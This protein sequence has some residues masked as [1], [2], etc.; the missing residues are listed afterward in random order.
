MIPSACITELLLL[1]KFDNSNPLWLELKRFVTWLWANYIITSWGGVHNENLSMM[2]TYCPKFLASLWLEIYR[3]SNWSFCYFE[4][5]KVDT[6]FVN[7][8]QVKIDPKWSFLLTL[9]RS[10]LFYWVWARHATKNNPKNSRTTHKIWH[11]SFSMIQSVGI[12]NWFPQSINRLQSLSFISSCN[13]FPDFCD[14][15]KYLW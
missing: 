5:F 2:F 11:K 3:F 13:T 1:P 9:D 12:K 10:Q 4:Q 14:K 7:F 8:G 15:I 6:N